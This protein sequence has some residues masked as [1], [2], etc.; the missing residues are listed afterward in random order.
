M[1]KALHDRGLVTLEVTSPI[2]DKF[3]TVA[4]LALVGTLE[5]DGSYD[6]APKHMVTPLGWENYVGFVCCPEHGTYR[7]AKRAGEFT[8]SFMH[9]DE[10]VLASLTAAPRCTGNEMPVL[11]L[12]ETFGSEVV[13]PPLVSGA[14]LYLECTLHGV[15]DDFGPNSLIAGEVV[16]AHVAE[17]S[18]RRPDRDDGELIAGQPMLVYL[19][20]CRYGS[21]GSSQSFPF[22]KGM[23]K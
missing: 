12:V 3:F 1:S 5:P 9:P 7:N 16:A 19:P 2:W 10:V 15:W 21:V 18:V 6:L 13:S 4:P 23:K 8:L 14:Y 11:G 17:E 20:P 22:H